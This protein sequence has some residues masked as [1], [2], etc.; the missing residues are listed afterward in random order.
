[1]INPFKARWRGFP[2]IE[3]WAGGFA[4]VL[5]LGVYLLKTGAG[6]EGQRIARTQHE[7][8]AEQRKIRLLQAEVAYLEQPERIGQL[9][10]AL[11]LQPLS[12]KQ[13]TPPEN[14]EDVAHAGG[15]AGGQPG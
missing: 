8:V 4:V 9:A 13:E 3:L 1:M 7:I 14:L 6:D 2:V 12:G 11:G 15:H 10:T 5:A